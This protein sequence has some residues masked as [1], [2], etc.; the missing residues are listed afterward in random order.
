MNGFVYRWYD[1]S[2]GKFY[3]GSHKGT[4]DDG[5]LGSGVLFRRAYAKRPELFIRDI[6]YTGVN[7]REYEQTI[8]DYE[9][10]ANNNIFYNLVNCA[11]GGAAYG[12]KNPFYGKKHSEKTKKN[13]SVK[14][15]GVVQ[16]IELVRKRT[17]SATKYKIYC[18]YN[19]KTYDTQGDCANDLNIS[20]NTIWCYLNGTRT[21]KLQLKKINK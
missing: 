16:S 9:D 17:I 10:A 6:M 7:Y 5:Y 12:D 3:I 1:V 21:N 13:W 18:G 14:R 8:L 11:W 2:N 20:K 15:K 4:P 19:N